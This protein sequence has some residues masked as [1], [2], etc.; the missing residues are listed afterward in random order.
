MVGKWIMMVAAVAVVIGVQC[1]SGVDAEPEGEVTAKQVLTTGLVVSVDE[2]DGILIIERATDDLNEQEVFAV[3]S[4]TI[5]FNIGSLT[6]LA[7]NDVVSVI[8]VE[9]GVKK[10]A[11]YVSMAEAEQQS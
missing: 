8:Y 1:V 5:L 10:V 11:R 2:R 9:E 6:E 7:S 3:T 4:D